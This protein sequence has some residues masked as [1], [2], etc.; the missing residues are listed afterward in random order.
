MATIEYRCPHHLR[1]A[2]STAGRCQRAFCNQPLVRSVGPTLPLVLSI[3]DA[4]GDELGAIELDDFR[5]RFPQALTVSEAALF[6]DDRAMSRI[7]E[8]VRIGSDPSAPENVRAGNACGVLLLDLATL[9]MAHTRGYRPAPPP[10]PQ[11]DP[12][13]AVAETTS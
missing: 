7:E 8:I 12:I 1:D 3:R 9:A 5:R 6:R 10:P 11:P 2:Y 13:D 4:N